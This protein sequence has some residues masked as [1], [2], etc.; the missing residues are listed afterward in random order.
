[1]ARVK[2]E[3]NRNLR[4][5]HYGFLGSKLTRNVRHAYKAYVLEKVPAAAGVAAG[6]KA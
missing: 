1:M 3:F 5:W 4:G 6:S 2:F